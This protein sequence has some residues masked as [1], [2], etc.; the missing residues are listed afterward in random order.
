MAIL[1]DGA[2]SDSLKEYYSKLLTDFIVQEDGK[3][4]VEIAAAVI[5]RHPVRSLGKYI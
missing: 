1:N 2:P 5:N 4:V 3:I